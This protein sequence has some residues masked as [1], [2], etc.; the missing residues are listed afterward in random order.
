[1]TAL[2]N[3]FLRGSFHYD[4]N[5]YLAANEP[6]VFHCNH[7]NCFLQAVL[8]DTID[9]IPEIESVLKDSA[10]EVAYSQ[11]KNFFSQNHFSI[12][13]KKEAIADYFQFAGFGKIDLNEID[14]NGGVV[15]TCYDHYGISWKIKFGLS[16][17][18]VSYF[19]SGFLAGAV[20]AI[21]STPCGTYFSSQQ[22][23]IAKG[24]KESLFRISRRLPKL[25]LRESQSE[26]NYSIHS[27]SQSSQT[28]VDYSGVREA[29]THMPLEGSHENGLIQAFGVLLT[30]HYANYYCNISYSFLRLFEAKMG[31]KGHKIATNLLTEAGHVCAFN[32]FGGIMQ[33]NEWNAL[34]R[35]MLKSH[36]DWIHGIVA[37]V[38]AFGWGFWEIEDFIP[39]E[40]LRLKIFSGYESNSYLA[41]FGKST[42]PISFLATGGVAGLM[43]L[44][45]VLKIPQK[46]P[47]TLDKDQYK[48]IHS[49]NKFFQAK[50]IKCRA[51]GDDFDLIEARRS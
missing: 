28:G 30:R 25:K 40:L 10:Q 4:R 2:K 43:N 45:Y 17:R 15:K 29:L 16:K 42:D 36:D 22:S 34:I 7:Y 35:P 12:D 26:G 20:D 49:S 13:E 39:N 14:T 47:I 31:F 21:Y 32:T 8:L 19:T 6:A 51:M 50:Q 38:N 27:L 48:L 9:Y 18:P 11:F 46:G 1:M 44:I 37:V 5:A 33:S 41:K 3:H 23:C 24:D